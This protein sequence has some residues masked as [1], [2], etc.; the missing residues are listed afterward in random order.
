MIRFPAALVLKKSLVAGLAAV[1]LA[2]SVLTLSPSQAQAQYYHRHRGFG[3][4]GLAAGI[5]GGLAA[6]AIIGGVTRPAYGYYAPPAYAPVP[7][8]VEPECYIERRRVWTGYGYAVRRF[9][10][11]SE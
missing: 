3:G 7:V 5:I 1:T 8:Y 4:G 11:C 6:G 10:V 2:A 9:R